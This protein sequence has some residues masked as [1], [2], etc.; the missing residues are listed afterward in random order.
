MSK[1][2]GT[3]RKNLLAPTYVPPVANATGYMAMAGGIQYI[4]PNAASHL[5]PTQ[6]QGL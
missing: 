3:S 6:F 5:K 4:V 1:T 2:D